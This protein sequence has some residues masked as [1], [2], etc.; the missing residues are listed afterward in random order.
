MDNV[1]INGVRYVP[2]K[3]PVDCS[4]FD[5]L[6]YCDDL[7]CQLTVREYLIKLLYQ[8]WSEQDYFSAKRPFGNSGWDL[9][10]I[11]GL[12]DSGHINGKIVR[13]YNDANRLI[14]ISD[15]GVDWKSAHQF[16]ANLIKQL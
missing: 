10:V 2:A 12:V 4:A 14:E 11:R 13:I 16:I 6:F 15:E 5:V 8:L 9:D 3:E 7:D 1:V